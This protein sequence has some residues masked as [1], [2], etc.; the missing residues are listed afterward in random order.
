MTENVPIYRYTAE[1]ARDHGELPE[2]RASYH[3]NV[4]CRN[5]IDAA[6]SKHYRNNILPDA[7]LQEVVAEFGVDRTL[8][9]LANT[10]RHKDWD[11]RFSP[12]NRRWA[13]EYPAEPEISAINDARSIDYVANSHS[14]LLDAIVRQAREKYVYT[15]KAVQGQQMGMM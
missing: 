9:V 1:Y 11:G 5:A 7:A 6:I 15:P 13:E 12:A 8:Y 4:A 2:Y 3:A 14:C 10:I